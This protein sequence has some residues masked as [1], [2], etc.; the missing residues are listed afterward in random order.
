MVIPLNLVLPFGH[1]PDHGAWPSRYLEIEIGLLWKEHKLAPLKQR[2]Y[3]DSSSAV[4][5]L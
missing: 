1:A 5:V 2:H 3:A 4:F